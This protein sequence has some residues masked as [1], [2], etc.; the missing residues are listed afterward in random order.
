MISLKCMISLTIFVLTGD[1]L[2]PDLNLTQPGFTINVHLLK[3]VK[4]FEISKKQVI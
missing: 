3:I 4:E 2:M 1:K